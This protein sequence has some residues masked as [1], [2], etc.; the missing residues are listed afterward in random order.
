MILH[1]VLKQIGLCRATGMRFIEWRYAPVYAILLSGA[2]GLLLVQLFIST[3][4]YV[5]L[6]LAALV[7]LLV[8]WRTKHNLA[9]EETFP[10]VLRVP[11]LNRLL[12]S[13]NPKSAS[14]R[15]F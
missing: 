7:S 1:N 2:V 10:E 4:L 15:R 5:L 13:T 9:I 8:L 3:E 14:T 6:P 11:I 12:R